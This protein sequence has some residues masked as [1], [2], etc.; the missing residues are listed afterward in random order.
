MSLFQIKAHFQVTEPCHGNA[1]KK[2]QN[3]PLCVLGSPEA[4]DQHFTIRGNF[5]H[6]WKPHRSQNQN[7]TQVAKSKSIACFQ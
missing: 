6:V 3:V 7:L 5:Q 1:I 4:K 2:W